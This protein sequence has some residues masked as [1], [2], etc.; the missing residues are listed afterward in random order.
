M[1]DK[2]TLN[3]GETI[4]AQDQSLSGSQTFGGLQTGEDAHKTI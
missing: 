2:K 4:P 3:V 1:P